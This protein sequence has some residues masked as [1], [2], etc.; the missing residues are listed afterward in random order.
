MKILL[1]EDN[2]N[3]L[4]VLEEVLTVAGHRVL[5][6]SDGEEGLA[7]FAAEQPDL[8][9]LDVQ[10]PGLDGYH[11]AQ[12]IRADGGDAWIPIIFLS[13]EG[14][15]EAINRGIEAGGDDYLVKPI[16]QAVLLAKLHAM[17]RIAKM[18]QRLLKLSSQLTEANEKL[19][20]IAQHDALTGLANRRL[21]DE[22]L[23][24]EWYRQRRHRHPLSLLLIDVDS[25]KAYNDYYG[26]QRGDD[27][28]QKVATVLQQGVRRSS[29]L[30][31]RY[32][33]EEFAVILPMLRRSGACELAEQLRIGVVNARL[34]H[35]ALAD[36]D[37]VTVSVGVASV[38]PCAGLISADLIAGADQA[39]YRAKCSGK[40]RVEY[41]PPKS[42]KRMSTAAE[43]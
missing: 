33:G 14:S 34:E 13:G 16:S 28:L 26:H 4:S 41:T 40:N 35:Q 19:Q 10:L 29:D 6:A 37:Y 31:A 20:W 38:I 2:K 43:S 27:C 11:I 7:L 30:V 36:T 1:V 5:A 18:R 17:E 42:I 39:L 12:R 23:A 15:D 32:G 24:Q 21:F 3:T 8:L 25:F 22:Y 9:L